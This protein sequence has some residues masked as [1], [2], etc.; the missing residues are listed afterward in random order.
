MK[1]HSI[2]ALRAVAAIAVV[3]FHAGGSIGSNVY[4]GNEWI[5]KLTRGFDSGVDLFFVISGF[6]ISI[7]IFLS[8]KKRTPFSFLYHRFW[9]VYP[10]AILTALIFITSAYFVLGYTPEGGFLG[11]ALSS[12]L[13][14]PSPIDPTPIVLWTLKQELLF[15]TIFSIC[16][17]HKKLGLSLV[18]VW[19]LLSWAINTQHWLADWFFHAQNIQFIFGMLVCFLYSEKKLIQH[20]ILLTLFGSLSFLALAFTYKS[21]DLNP[22][23]ASLL[24][25]I[26][27]AALIM[28]F[29]NGK[30]KEY[31][32][33]TFLGAASYSIYLIHFFFISLFQ[34]ALIRFSHLIPDIISLLILV[35]LS[36]I[37]GIM[38]YLV[39]EKQIERVRLSKKA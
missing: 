35:T 17:F 31:K 38:Y 12:V 33:L 2:Q 36:T 11:A 5:G 14:L 4:Q 10:M 13:L 1:I 20:S 7:P 18:I 8:K 3:M 23:T 16:F 39:S 24:F 27:G 9:R 30:W 19:G 21:M 32:I 34:K 28:G 29:A 22:Q 26:A 15:Y 6:V 37:C 25:G